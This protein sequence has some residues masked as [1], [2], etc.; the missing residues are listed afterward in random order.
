VRT[1]GIV[2]Q[3]AWDKKLD[4]PKYPA[5][6]VLILANGWSTGSIIIIFFITI[7]QH[8][9]HYLQVVFDPCTSSQM[10]PIQVIRKI[11]IFME[12]AN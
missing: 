10:S 8:Q 1:L 9:H 5:Q 6:N 7:H 4:V 2:A 12:I 11:V 3:K